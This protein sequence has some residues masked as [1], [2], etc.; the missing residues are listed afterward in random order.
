MPPVSI[1]W[2]YGGDSG[3][4]P[5]PKGWKA[6]DVLPP[7]GGGIFFGSQGAIVFGP[8][9]ASLPLTASTGEYKPVTWGTPTKIRMFPEELEKS[10]KVKNP[11]NLHRPFNHWW[12][13][14]E[15][16]KARKPAGAPFSYGG[17]LTETALLGNAGFQQP[18]KI[19]S[20]DAKTGLFLNNE[21]ANRFLKVTYRPGF[22]LPA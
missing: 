16:A 2:H 19:L 9:Y 8:I 4:I 21:E 5:L 18:G 12:D 17:L 13:W 10:Y 15:S 3:H 14:A 20:Y 1:T 6:A 11:L 7:A 22:E